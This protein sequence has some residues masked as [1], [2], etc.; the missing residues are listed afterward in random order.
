[1]L[2]LWVCKYKL[3]ES[4]TKR[5]MWR[6]FLSKKQ[7]QTSEHH[8][9]H[10]S[11]VFNGIGEEELHII[12]RW[13]SREFLQSGPDQNR[14]TGPVLFSSASLALPSCS[15]TISTLTTLALRTSYCIKF[16]FFLKKKKVKSILILLYW[17][18]PTEMKKSRKVT[19]ITI[20]WNWSSS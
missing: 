16:N 17:N 6:N 20:W 10:V 1:M 18:Q 4:S 7:S 2:I 12:W 3:E 9:K 5:F 11:I 19:K 15:S 14:A 8:R 13:D